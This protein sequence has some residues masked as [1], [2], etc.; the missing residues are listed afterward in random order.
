MLACQ[1]EMCWAELCIELRP[2]LPEWDLVLSILDT[3]LSLENDMS[4]L[5]ASDT[6]DSSIA[7][8]QLRPIGSL[9]KFK[10]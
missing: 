3:T 8:K 4:V 9:P 7:C 2:A 6:A 1:Y 10:L 5:K